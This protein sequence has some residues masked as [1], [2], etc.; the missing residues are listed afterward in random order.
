LRVPMF[1]GA[2]NDAIGKANIQ[3]TTGF[4]DSSL[5]ST[6]T[7]LQGASLSLSLLKGFFPM[8]SMILYS[9]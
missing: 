5:R 3:R 1:F 4:S 6:L 9:A 8:V 7:P 2:F